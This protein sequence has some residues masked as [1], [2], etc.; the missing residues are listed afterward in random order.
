MEFLSLPHVAQFVSVQRCPFKDQSLGS[1]R[2]VAFYHFQRLDIKQPHIFSVQRMEVWGRM[3]PK[4]SFD[5][6]AIKS[7]DL[8]HIGARSLLPLPSR[9]AG[10]TPTS[11]RRH[12][13]T[14]QT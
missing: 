2:E 9:S 1:W 8:G 3:V 7:G 10:T 5:D 14:L 6:N 11:D 13:G 12:Q 4:E